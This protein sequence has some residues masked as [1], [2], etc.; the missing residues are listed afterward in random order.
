MPTTPIKNQQTI[1]AI[2]R[3]FELQ[4]KEQYK[5]ANST[6]KERRA[7]LKK[8]Q[9]AL[10]STFNREMKDAA[11]KDFRKHEM[12]VELSEVF[13]VITALK[14]TSKNLK[15]W[16]R[17]KK[18]PTPISFFGFSSKVKY[19]PKGVVLIISPW[20]FAFNLSFIPLISA[21]AA[22]NAVILKPSEHTPH[23]SKLIKKIV[24]SIFDEKEVAVI[25]GGVPETTHLL[26]KPFNHIFFT[27]A[28]S[29]GKIVMKAAAKH[30]T[31]VSLELG[32]KSPTIVDETADI[33]AAA[34]RIAWAKGMNNGQICIAPDYVYVHKSVKDKFVK[35]YKEQVKVLY[36]DDPKSSPSY[37]RIVNERHFRRLNNYLEDAVSKGGTIEMGGTVDEK[38]NYIAPTL[39]SNLKEESK[40]W[41]E[42]IFGPILPIRTFEDISEPIDYINAGEKPLALY[43]YSKH[44]GNIKNVENNTR[45]GGMV[46]NYSATHYSNPHLPFGGSNNSGIGKGNG[47]YGFQAFS[48]AK[49]VQKHWSPIDGMK[50]LQ[51]PYTPDKVKMM[52]SVTK[53]FS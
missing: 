37:N 22:G 31:S 13:A 52:R 14:H 28:P 20:N 44:K 19:E 50:M 38:E 9:V 35:A 46:I 41:Q 5:I 1:T 17:D 26:N 47:Y 11:Y 12:E 33:D 32:G 10:E 49:A 24:E 51:A 21:I 23:S 4:K 27:G 18:V 8:L 29:I 53:W 43:I 6:A 3:I 16:M 39:V 34:A 15:K 30:L 42:E 2:D 48:N 45:A 36:G 7:K 40:L 25:E